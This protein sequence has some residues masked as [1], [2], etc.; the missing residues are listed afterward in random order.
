MSR[1][2]AGH[3]QELEMPAP[4]ALPAGPWQWVGSATLTAFAGPWGVSYARNLTPDV[5]TGLGAW[6]EAQFV[7]SARTGRHQGVPEGRPILPPMP[8]RSLAAMTDEDLAAMW[9][10][11]QSIPALRN[12]APQSVPALPPSPPAA[13]PAG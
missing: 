5:E 4:P 3:P 8:W 6:T 13:A 12:D 11:L 2:L 10:Y 7:R 1:M 9:A